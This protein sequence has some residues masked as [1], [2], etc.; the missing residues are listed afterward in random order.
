[1]GNTDYSVGFEVL[2][3]MIM[4]VWDITPRLATCFHAGIVLSLFDHENGSD[5]FPETS[6]DFQRTAR[7]YILLH[8]VLVRDVKACISF[9]HLKSEIHV[10]S[11]DVC[12]SFTEN[13][14]SPLQRPVG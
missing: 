3:A 12:L 13:T 14:V 2:T 10:N 7:R 4:V 5:M 8:T 1:M 11:Y 6:D 9:N